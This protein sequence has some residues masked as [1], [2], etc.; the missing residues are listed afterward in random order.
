LDFRRID[1]LS[2]R[3]DTIPVKLKALKELRD[4]AP[5]RRFDIHLSD[6]RALPV[7]TADHLLLMPN[8]NEEFFVVLPDGGFRIVDVSQVESAGRGPERSKTNV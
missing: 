1:T 6:G 3:L 8:N 5:F 7:V 4:T 2:P